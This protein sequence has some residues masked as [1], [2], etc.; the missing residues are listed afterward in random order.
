MSVPVFESGVREKFS[1]R[2]PFLDYVV[3]LI[4]GKAL[5]GQSYNRQWSAVATL[6]GLGALIVL[7]ILVAQL[8]NWYLK[9]PLFL[10][11]GILICGV[12]R[13]LQVVYMH[14]CIHNA[15]FKSVRKNEIF[16]DIISGM[17]LVQCRQAYKHDHLKHHRLSY[18]TT[19]QD[20]DAAALLSFGFLPGRSEGYYWR[21]LLST[22]FDPRFHA[23]FLWSRFKSSVVAGGWLTKATAAISAISILVGIWV[24]FTLTFFLVLLPLLYFYHISALLQ[25]LTEHQWLVT[26]LPCNNRKEYR[27]RC[28]AR[29]TGARRGEGVSGWC[30]WGVGLIVFAIPV[31]FGCWVGDLPVHDWHHLCGDLNHSPTDWRQGLFRRQDAI[32]QGDTLDLADREI[33]GLRTA[34]VQVFQG[35]RDSSLTGNETFLQEVRLSKARPL[36]GM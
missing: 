24:N 25:F 18:F 7:M 14:H 3:T 2:Y 22:L 27:K 6:L 29:F 33:W 28:W 16:A 15:V 30:R 12:F 5:P 1:L 35:L 8:D 20:S 17:I 36:A 23:R 26:R 31:R 13:L 4:V 34:L 21:L 10:Y 19:A 32:D 9:A 11:L